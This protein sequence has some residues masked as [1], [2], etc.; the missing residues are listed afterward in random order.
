MY[1]YDGHWWRAIASGAGVEKAQPSEKG[2]YRLNVW[3]RATSKPA[4]ALIASA[5]Y[6]L[7]RLTSM[8]ER[9]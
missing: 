7:V 5:R 1:G 3:A 8:L 6:I 2:L 9:A 4:A